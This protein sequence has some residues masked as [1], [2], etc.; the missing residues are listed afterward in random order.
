M[1]RFRIGAWRGFGG[2]GR[3]RGTDGL[4]LDETALAPEP[5]GW[6][7]SKAWSPASRQ[8]LPAAEVIS[9]YADLWHVGHS[10]R[11]SKSDLRAARCWPDVATP[12][13]RT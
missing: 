12:S 9:S 7:A 2:C 1:S 13:R 5:G 3:P 6:P 4:V 10:F 11:M 8:V